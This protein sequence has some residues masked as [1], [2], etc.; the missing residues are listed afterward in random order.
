[1]TRSRLAWA[2][3]SAGAAV[4]SVIAVRIRADTQLLRV[5]PC[6]RSMTVSASIGIQTVPAGVEGL[7]VTVPADDDEEEAVAVSAMVVL[8]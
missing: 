2:V 8:S 7:A 6:K 3:F 1:M 5:S 4:P